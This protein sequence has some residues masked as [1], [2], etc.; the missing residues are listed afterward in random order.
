MDKIIEQTQDIPITMVFN[1]AGYI[2]VSLFNKTPIAK[3]VANYNCNATSS[4]YLTHHFAQ[5]MATEKLKGLIS[6][7][8]TPGGFFPAPLTTMYSSTK[9]F[10]T[11]FFLLLLHRHLVL[12]WQEN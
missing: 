6:F 2:F 1:N 5:R 4:I 10:L 11:V 8:S 3:H 7:T 12:P 9:A